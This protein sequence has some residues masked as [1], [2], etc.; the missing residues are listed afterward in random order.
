MEYFRYGKPVTGKYFINRE[1]ELKKIHDILSEIPK[2][3]G[4]NIALIGLRRTGKT[5]LLKNCN[6][7]L[8]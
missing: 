2:G 7:L 4:N 6:C 5:S 1:K 3:G 8:V